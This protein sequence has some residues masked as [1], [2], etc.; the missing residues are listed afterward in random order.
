MGHGRIDPTPEIRK[1]ILQK[2]YRSRSIPYC[3]FT[4]TPPAPP[5]LEEGGRRTTRADSVIAIATPLRYFST[6]RK[7]MSQLVSF[8]IQPLD[9]WLASLDVENPGIARAIVR[10]IPAR[11]PFE[12]DVVWFGRSLFRIPPL[13]KL[14]PLYDRFV[15]L[16]FRALCYLVDT[17]GDYELSNS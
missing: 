1:A 2:L 4:Q 17:V 14:N 11:C 10:L 6:S 13:C 8:L 5:R 3:F 7:V 12:R 15:E 16:R 9:R